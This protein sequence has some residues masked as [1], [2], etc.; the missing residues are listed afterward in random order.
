VATWQFTLAGK[1][2]RLDD[3][4]IDEVEGALN[5]TGVNW[6]DFERR[7]YD[8]GKALVAFV[9]YLADDLGVEAP[10]PLT[11]PKLNDLYEAR[12]GRRARGL[13]R[14]DA[15]PKSGRPDDGM[16]VWFARTLGWAPD[17]VRRQR[18]RDLRLIMNSYEPTF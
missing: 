4:G 13:H 2:V 15:G 6:Y 8:S 3:L 17:V 12:R 14:W 5:G 16:I 7:P 10:M 18:L 11:P 1:V 9:K